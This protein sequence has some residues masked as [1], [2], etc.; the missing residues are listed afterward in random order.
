[1]FA[2]SNLVNPAAARSAAEQAVAIARANAVLATRKVVLANAD[3]VVTTWTSAFKK[4]PFDVPLETKIGFLLKLNQTALVPGV[5]F[6]NSQVLF[7]DEQKFF[8]SS[9]G[10]RITQ[11]L[12][13]TYPQF[14]TTAADRAS[15][16]FQTRG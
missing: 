16:D 15:G 13:R 12:V 11:R 3:K 4:D 10:S 1:G 8:A 9:E 14:T 6:V 7:A 5:S 2:A